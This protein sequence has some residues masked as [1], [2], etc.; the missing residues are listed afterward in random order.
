MS[1]PRGLVAIL[2]VTA[3]AVVVALVAQPSG[4]RGWLAEARDGDD[5]WGW[6]LLA[7]QARDAYNGDRDAYLADMRRADWAA[8]DLGD[9]VDVWS[10]DGFFHVQAELHSDPATVPAFLLERRIIHGVCHPPGNRP[11]AIGVFEDRRMFQGGT[12][13]GGGL[14]GTQ[15]RC[16]A[17]FTDSGA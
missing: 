17:A 14:S 7:E 13:G 15:I 16:N 11:T 10:D 2:V 5:D 4:F 9:P 1:R 8:L 6:D 12:W 3:V